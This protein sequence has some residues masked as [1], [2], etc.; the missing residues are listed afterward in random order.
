MALESSPEQVPSSPGALENL[1]K[2]EYHK[3]IRYGNPCSGSQCFLLLEHKG[4]VAS[5][6]QTERS[7]VTMERWLRLLEVEETVEAPSA[8]TGKTLRGQRS[9][10]AWVEAA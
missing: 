1:Q 7:R 10:S 3:S 9:W 5:S 6:Q 4:R 2:L 8:R